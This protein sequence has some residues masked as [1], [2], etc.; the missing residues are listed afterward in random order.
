MSLHHYEPVYLDRLTIAMRQELQKGLGRPD[1]PEVYPVLAIS[2]SLPDR[3]P[4]TLLYAG[5]GGGSEQAGG[6][7]G[8]IESWGSVPRGVVVKGN[9]LQ[10]LYVQVT[11][12]DQPDVV[13]DSCTVL[14]SSYPAHL[15]RSPVTIRWLSPHVAYADAAIAFS[16]VLASFAPGSPWKWRLRLTVDDIPLVGG[17]FPRYTLTSADFPQIHAD[18]L[19]Q[20]MPVCYGQH[21][22]DGQGK[23]GMINLPLVDTINK[24]YLVTLGVAEGIDIVH[25]NTTRLLDTEWSRVDQQV[26]GK[27]V[28]LVEVPSATDQDTISA[29][30]R[31]LTD[32]GDGSGRLIRNPVRQIR[33]WLEAF[34]WG[35]WSQGA[36]PASA[37]LDYT[38]FA[39][40]E[41]LCDAAGYEGSKYFAGTEP[42]AAKDV[43]NEWADCWE[44][45]LFWTAAGK[46]GIVVLDAGAPVLDGTPWLLG[47]EEAS[48]FS[49]S[50]DIGG[51]C[52]RVDTQYVYGSAD[53]KYFQTLVV[54]DRSGDDDISVSR[55]QP[56]AAARVS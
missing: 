33:H 32:Q 31:G 37:P 29:D 21:L 22:S 2:L 27:A 35:Q 11:L 23:A 47:G 26:N 28:T 17:F 52:T 44:I 46:L 5:V 53:G 9:Q 12:A 4:S 30:L 7:Q 38:L 1:T 13:A 6:Y 16:G 8:R 36:Y 34:V 55:Q 49:I 18:A 24:R 40:A 14:A 10:G 19:G 15:R 25:K 20:I 50:E 42:F 3:E 51:L 39:R 41:A 48:E 45:K 54:E 43:L 56:W